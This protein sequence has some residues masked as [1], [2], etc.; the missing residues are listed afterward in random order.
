MNI[1]GLNLNTDGGTYPTYYAGIPCNQASNYENNDFLS[2]NNNFP[3]WLSVIN[4]KVDLR[5]TVVKCCAS[6]PK[7][8]CSYFSDWPTDGN[9][10]TDISPVSNQQ[11]AFTT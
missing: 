7:N 3:Y 11:V 2:K 6:D 5:I 1:P 9:Y 8:Y 10:L 4:A